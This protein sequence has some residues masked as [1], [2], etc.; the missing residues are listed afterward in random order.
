MPV[1]LASMKLSKETK[2]G[3]YQPFFSI[4]SFGN[5]IQGHPNMAKVYFYTK[6]KVDSANPSA[7]PICTKLFYLAPF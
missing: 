3:V 7:L 1:A 4:D 6:Y 5:V 2:H